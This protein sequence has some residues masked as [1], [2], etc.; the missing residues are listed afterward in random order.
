[1]RKFL[2]ITLMLIASCLSIAAQDNEASDTLPEIR[3]SLLLVDAGNAEYSICGHAAIRME[4][5]SGGLDFCFSY[6]SE[7]DAINVMRLLLGHARGRTIAV[8]WTDYEA[9]YE[10]ERRGITALPL[11]L[12]RREKQRL[13][14]LL[15]QQIN[16][17]TTT[18]D[19]LKSSCSSVALLN[20][21]RALDNE[22]IDWGE[23]QS[24]CGATTYRDIIRQSTAGHPWWQSFWLLTLGGT[25]GSQNAEPESLPPTMLL[26][27]LK[28]ATLRNHAGASRPLLLTGSEKTK[29]PVA[30][31]FSPPAIASLTL[32]AL[33]FIVSL[34][35]LKGRL[36]PTAKVID[37]LLLGIQTLLGLWLTLMLCSAHSMVRW[38]PYIIVFNIV[39]LLLWLTLRR[40]PCRRKVLTAYAAALAL[41]LVCC[42]ND[43]TQ[44]P[45][46]ALVAA[47]L[48]R[49]LAKLKTEEQNV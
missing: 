23:W 10:G 31:H 18:F 14:Q 4:Y 6:D 7:D 21:E 8:K 36:K 26:S 30:S 35:N 29:K 28:N 45:L 34:A 15:D 37:G 17:N 12:T 25:D 27:V 20:I 11:N 43:Y 32:L 48:I 33:T 38:N 5:P 19:I 41:F 22:Y 49:C 9:Q 24:K 46:H 44:I 16:D 39:P 1:M 42:I 40:K 3:A 47:M 13:W 2:S